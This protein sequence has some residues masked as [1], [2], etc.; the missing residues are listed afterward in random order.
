MRRLI[1]AGISAIMFLA[2]A[3]ADTEPPGDMA[4][5]GTAADRGPTVVR[6]V[7]ETKT[8]RVLVPVRQR[9]RPRWHIG[10]SA[11]GPGIAGRLAK[12][13]PGCRLDA[14][15]AESLRHVALILGARIQT[16]GC[17]RSGAQQAALYALKPGLAAPPGSSL[18]E[19]GL[20]IDIAARFLARFPRVGRLLYLHGWHQFAPGFEPWHFSY[21]LI[22]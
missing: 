2:G 11:H 12:Y 14:G 10:R 7:V 19:R 18:H 8:R 20:A 9:P 5:V 21:R 4:P 3:I 16:V 13:G 17:W 1:T 15:A 22:G 6:T